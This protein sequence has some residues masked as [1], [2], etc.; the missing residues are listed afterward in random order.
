MSTLFWSFMSSEKAQSLSAMKD[1]VLQKDLIILGLA[2]RVLGGLTHTN[3]AHLTKNRL[4]SV[5]IFTW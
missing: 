1:Q 3:P 2:L 4:D 5:A